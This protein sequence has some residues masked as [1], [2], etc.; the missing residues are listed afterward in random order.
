MSTQPSNTPI[1]PAP[2]DYTGADFDSCR[3]VLQT[4]VNQAFPKWT[5]FNRASPGNVLLLAMCYVLDILT[6]YQNDQARETFWAT[7]QRRRN[8]LAL[9]RGVGVRLKGISAASA[10]IEFT[11]TTALTNDVIIPQGT[12]IA[13]QGLEENVQFFTT[14]SL[15]IPAGQTQGTVSAI[16]A[17]SQKD[18]LTSD[19]TASQRL[20]TST[21]DYVDNSVSVT[22]GLTE[23]VRVENL[24]NSS[25]TDQHYTIEVDEN[26]RL[27]VIFGNG[28]NGQIPPIGAVSVAYLTG[29]GSRGNVAADTITSLATAITD[30]ANNPV[31]IAATNPT[32]ASGGSD[33]ETVEQARRR[34]PGALRALT[35]TVSRED[36]EINALAVPG[37]ARTMMLTNDEDSS[38]PDNQGDLLILAQ[39]DPPAVPSSAALKDAVKAQVTTVFPTMITFNVNVV[40]PTLNTI[41]VTADVKVKNGFTFAQV[42]ANINAALKAFFALED[43]NGAPNTNID[44]GANLVDQLVTFTALFRAVS[45]AAGVERVDEDAFLPADDVVLTLREFPVLGTVTVNQL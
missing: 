38:V 13:T 10:D 9:A 25:P 28:V 23:W 12:E 6:K 42:E 15:K 37:V 29:G 8:A 17:T 26:D 7:V 34:V 19:G 24:F 2:Q 30:L 27:F 3:E 32:A 31:Q 39:A 18:A 35:R 1:L 20:R 4:D 36:F 45:G 21:V 11:L 16:A 22:V 41:D 43:A 33:R 40:D 44:F 5:D 14:A